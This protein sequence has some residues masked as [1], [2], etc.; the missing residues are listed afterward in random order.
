MDQRVLQ[1]GGVPEHF[2]M[3]WHLALHDQYFSK[4]GVQVNW[5]DYPEGTGT[6]MRDLR[7]G[8]LDVAVALTEGVVAEIVKTQSCRIVQYYVTS[9]LRWGIHVAATTS[10]RQI[11]DLKGKTFAISRPGSGSQLMTY[12]LAQQEQWATDALAFEEIGTIDGARQALAAGAA[13]GFLWEQS[14]TQPLVTNG[15]FRRIGTL[16]TPWPCFVVAVRTPL[17]DSPSVKILLA[18]L[19][20]AVMQLQKDPEV[21]WA[22]IAEKYALPISEVQSW[23]TRTQWA[24]DQR[25]ERA[26]LRNV[27]DTLNRVGVITEMSAPEALC[28]GECQLV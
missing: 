12:V 14:M 4:Q 7:E 22:M 13:D 26:V 28:G 11:S 16:D 23:W 10:Y 6:L 3:P 27:L 19:H 20:Q 21:A 5:K 2:N 25:V 17:V 15:E 1:V 9:P 24:T 8:T 18:A